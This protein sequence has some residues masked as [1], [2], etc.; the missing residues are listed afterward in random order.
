MIF[1]QD[2]S[3]ISVHCRS[4]ASSCTSSVGVMAF[5]IINPF[6]RSKF[7]SYKLTRID[8]TTYKKYESA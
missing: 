5:S 7:S 1:L 2:S 3:T 4:G 6:S 8:E